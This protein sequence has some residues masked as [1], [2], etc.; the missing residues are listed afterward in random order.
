MRITYNL[1]R[2]Q[3]RC[4]EITFDFKEIT[5]DDNDA[6][7]NYETYFNLVRIFELH[8]EIQSNNQQQ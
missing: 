6:I 7:E 4:L 8:K 3:K 2:N 1:L 5:Q